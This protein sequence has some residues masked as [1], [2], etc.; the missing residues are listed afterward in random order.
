MAREESLMKRLRNVRRVLK[1]F[2]VS[3]MSEKRERLLCEIRVNLKS[4]TRSLDTKGAALHDEI[5]SLNQNNIRLGLR[6]NRYSLKT[7]EPG[8]IDIR[9]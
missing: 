2:S 9:T 8:L 1:S 3:P 4:L 7:A 6:Y 5:G